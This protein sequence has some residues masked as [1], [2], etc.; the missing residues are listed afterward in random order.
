MVQRVTYLE[1]CANSS[2]LRFKVYE[3]ATKEIFHKKYTKAAFTGPNNT[4]STM[5]MWAEI[6]EDGGDFQHD[7][8][9]TG[10][11][12][13]ISD[14]LDF[15]WYDRVWFKEEAGLRETQ[16]GLFLV[17]LHKVGSLMIYWILPASGIPFLRTM[18]QRVTYLETCTDAINQH[19]EVY[20]KF[21]KERFHEKYTEEA[22]AGPNSAKPIMEI[23]TE[24]V[25]DDEDL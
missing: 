8:L 1:T 15:G 19:V 9:M 17:P 24:L 7:E 18:V 13:E 12:P 23:W 6:A 25:K 4:K 3:K 16:I 2:K 11:T 5:E 21:I 10:E 14:Y 20:D 22:F